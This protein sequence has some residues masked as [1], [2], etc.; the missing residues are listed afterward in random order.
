MPIYTWRFCHSSLCLCGGLYA[1]RRAASTVNSLHH[2]VYICTLP[3]ALLL[4]SYK[5]ADEK[6]EK[7]NVLYIRITHG[8][9]AMTVVLVVDGVVAASVKW[10]QKYCMQYARES[11][12][13]RAHKHCV[14]LLYVCG[15][16]LCSITA[17]I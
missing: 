16:R 14:C 6:S 9:G 15:L 17:Y 5:N 10:S 13:K 2:I 11:R 1:P 3:H 8:R 7:C 4:V 12:E